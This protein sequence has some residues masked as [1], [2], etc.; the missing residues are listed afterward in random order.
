MV[1][2]C[3]SRLDYAT[4]MFTWGLQIYHLDHLR[5]S[6]VFGVTILEMSFDSDFWILN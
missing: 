2:D 4:L 3:L 1:A 5:S 6:V